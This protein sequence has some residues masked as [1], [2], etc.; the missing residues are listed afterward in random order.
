LAHEQ[1]R[2]RH[3]DVRIDSC[4]QRLDPD[5]GRTAIKRLCAGEIAVGSGFD[6]Q[7]FVVSCDDGS[8]NP[9]SAEP[10]SDRSEKVDVLPTQT[11]RFHEAIAKNGQHQGDREG[12]AE[13]DR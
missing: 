9:G 3:G 1:D 11:G 13:V 8:T 10:T 6:A 2:A 12:S 7:G 5:L 4:D